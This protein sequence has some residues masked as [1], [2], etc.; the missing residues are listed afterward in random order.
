M[1]NVKFLGLVSE[2]QKRFLFENSDLMIMPTL[3]ETKIRS[4]EGF[5]ISYIEA[6]FFGLPSI[7]SSVGGTPEAVINNSTG[8][9]INN[10]NEL[11][12]VTRNLLKG[13]GES[14]AD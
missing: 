9:I 5:G 10:L 12:N 13:L 6:A 11:Y 8:M 4:I 14:L 7:A 2:N 3:D 1:S